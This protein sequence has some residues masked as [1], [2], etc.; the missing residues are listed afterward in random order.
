MI[1]KRIRRIRNATAASATQRAARPHALECVQ[2]HTLL[3]MLRPPRG[4]RLR[5]ACRL[6]LGAGEGGDE[7]GR[8]YLQAGIQSKHL[9]GHILA[10]GCHRGR[11]ADTRIVGRG[12][13]VDDVG[14]LAGGVGLARGCVG[15]ARVWAGEVCGAGLWPRSC[16]LCA[17]IMRPLFPSLAVWKHAPPQNHR[18]KI[19]AWDTHQV[20]HIALGHHTNV[21]G[22]QELHR[23]QA[24]AFLPTLHVR[25]SP[26]HD[27]ADG[28]AAAAV[29]A[30]V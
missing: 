17:S 8:L 11:Q 16:Q 6:A 13:H 3:R 1:A 23:E 29:A 10:Q 27:G 12:E 4:H 21:A 7:G 26:R 28:P 22:A 2:L 18:E 19:G 14:G 24:A 25:T 9:C 15:G 5:L 20:V 30:A